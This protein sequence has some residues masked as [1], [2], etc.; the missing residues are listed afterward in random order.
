MKSSGKRSRF[1][2]TAW[3]SAFVGTPRQAAD[4]DAQSVT[5]RRLAPVMEAELT[6][7]PVALVETYAGEEIRR[8]DVPGNGQRDAG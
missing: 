7:E 2:V 4:G 5:P 8:R 6:E 1:L 3:L